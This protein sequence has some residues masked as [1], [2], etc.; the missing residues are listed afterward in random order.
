MK[1]KFA[2]VTRC[3]DNVKE[4]A[5]LTHPILEDYAARWGCDFVVLDKKEGWMGDDYELAHYRILEVKKLLEQYER[6]LVI[7]SD[8][9]L[10]PGCPNPFDIVPKDKIGTIYEDKGSRESMRQGVIIKIQERFG[11]VGWEEGYINTGFFVVSRQHKDIFQR[12]RS[13]HYP[14]QEK[15]LRESEGLWTGFG[16]DDALIGYNIHK[17]DHEVHELPYQFNHMSMFSESW[18]NSASRFDSWVI[19]Y[20]GLANFPDDQ[21]GR[22]VSGDNKMEGRIQLIKNDID[23]ITEGLMTFKDAAPCEIQ[24]LGS[25]CIDTKIGVQEK[26]IVVKIP[27][28]PQC[29]ERELAVLKLG[30]P[31]TV[32]FLGLGEDGNF[33]QFFMLE[34]L[35]PLPDVIDE[36]LMLKIATCTLITMR[37]LYKFGIPWICKHEHILQDESGNI[38][39]IDFGDDPYTPIPFYGGKGDVEAIVMEG[40]CCG[41]NKYQMRYKYPLSGYIAIMKNLC[42]RNDLSYDILT[43]AEKN[44]ITHEYQS[45]KD[46][47]QPIWFEEYCGVPRTESELNDPAFGTLVPANRECV[48]RAGI[49]YENLEPWMD[50]DTTWLDI[51]CNVGW[52]VFELS[53]QFSVYGIDADIEKIAFAKMLAEG[54]D[55]D[56]RFKCENVNMDTIE[57][58][59]EHDVISAMS[60]LHLKLV[61]DKDSAAFWILF[62]AV[63][64]K[65]KKCMFFEFPPHSYGYAG[66]LT[67]ETFRAMVKL[68][69]G[70]ASVEEIGTTDAGRPFLKCLKEGY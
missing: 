7:D 24:G 65:A 45:L 70:F 46:V 28:T 25:R 10:M 57:A 52:F 26:P 38:K 16:F 43:E 32:G 49:I 53:E 40:E 42:D 14:E 1:H 68:N 41:D 39:L 30:I 9:L 15:E 6:V 18:N 47:H 4:L 19:H 34:K 64:D 60:M 22:V 69:G 12:A 66:A 33:G 31:G 35:H 44:M 2:M 20:A 27:N 50:E 63:A 62:G 48:D 59:P 11:D 56:A 54:S 3:D 23:R 21:S 36:E 13:V 17:F 67:A 37:Q 5:D 61:A 8:I 55:T 51:G 29:R 58:M